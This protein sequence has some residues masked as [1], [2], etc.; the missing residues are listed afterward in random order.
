MPEQERSYRQTYLPNY[1][2]CNY[3]V[4]ALMLKTIQISVHP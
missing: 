3:I 1:A 4:G 2:K